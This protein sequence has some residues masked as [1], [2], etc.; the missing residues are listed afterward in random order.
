MSLSM[1]QRFAEMFCFKAGK[2][3]T[4][5]LQIVNAAYGDQGLSRSKVI[6]CMDD[7]VMDE[8]TLKTK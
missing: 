8:K 3:T 1:E 4:E 5:N 2:S 6:R 7:F